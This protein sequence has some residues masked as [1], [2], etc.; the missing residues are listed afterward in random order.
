MDDAAR[1]MKADN[2]ARGDAS[3][4]AAMDAANQAREQE[5]R[6]KPSVPVGNYGGPHR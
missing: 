2:A 3:R 5:L 4:T 1:M 6:S